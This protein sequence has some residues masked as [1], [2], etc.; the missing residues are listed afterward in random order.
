M[1]ISKWGTGAINV[2][3]CESHH[4]PTV[5]SKIISLRSVDFYIV[6]SIAHDGKEGRSRVHA[7]WYSSCEAIAGV[8][9]M[10]AMSYNLSTTLR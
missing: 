5:L 10:L 1:H 2:A 3:T 6:G 7:G 8:W 4:A 9:S